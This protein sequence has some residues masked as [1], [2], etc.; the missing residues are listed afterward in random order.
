MKFIL[1]CWL[2]LCLNY[3]GF[4][5]D[6]T[7]VSSFVLGEV[8]QIESKILGEERLVNIYL[9]EGYSK[10]DKEKYPV[11]YLL[12][13][14]K[15]EDFI[16]TVGL[17]Q[18]NT[19]PWVDRMPKSIVVGISNSD[20]KRDFT[21]STQIKKDKKRYPTSG[22]SSNFIQFLEKELQ[23]YINTQFKT[24]GV[25][26]LIGQSLGGLLAVE[27][28][29]EHSNLFDNYIVIS[30]S[31]WWDNRSLLE[32]VGGLKDL[33]EAKKVYIGV[34]QEGHAS[35]GIRME[36]DAKNFYNSI[37][38]MKSIQATYDYL[39]EENHATVGHIALMHAF[40]WLYN[41]K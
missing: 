33:P 16:H 3:V 9:P 29:L 14:S 17:V 41:S 25:S 21:Y 8:H 31:L 15:D 10:E 20:R 18:Y 13:G 28:L 6:S 22:R 4:T 39:P 5:Q 30:P 26:T 36:D 32:K 35:K 40:I 1:T 11:I 37:K 12:D 2:V 38:D 19:F 23:P 27:I 24:N 34:G 7:S